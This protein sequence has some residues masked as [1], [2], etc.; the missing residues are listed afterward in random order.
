MVK[1]LSSYL[2]ASTK[3]KLPVQKEASSA[4]QDG[5]ELTQNTS[6]PLKTA[7]IIHLK[8]SNKAT[9]CDYSM[10]M[11]YTRSRRSAVEVN[12]EN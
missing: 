4:N 11:E 8:K 10:L 3:R 2:P 6:I 7:R 5:K 1:P 12:K 9:I